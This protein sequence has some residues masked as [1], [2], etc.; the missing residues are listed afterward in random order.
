MRKKGQGFEVSTIVK[1]VVY[2]LALIVILVGVYAGYNLFMRI[3]GG[4]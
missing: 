4:L 3:F 1:W 2:V